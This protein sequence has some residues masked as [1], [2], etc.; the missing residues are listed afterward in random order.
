MDFACV[1][2]LAGAV[3]TRVKSLI[4][5]L[6]RECNGVIVYRELTAGGGG[7]NPISRCRG[8]GGGGVVVVNPVGCFHFGLLPA[9]GRNRPGSLINLR[10][11]RRQMCRI[12]VPPPPPTTERMRLF[13]VRECVY[14]SYTFVVVVTAAAAPLL[15]ITELN[16]ITRRGWQRK[17]TMRLTR[18]I[19]RESTF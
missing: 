15:T 9:R 10:C 1:Y 12:V 19:L 18:T 3:P 14:V 16:K 4:S 11:L 2:P 6:R 8:K 17:W 13:P 5:G 7:R